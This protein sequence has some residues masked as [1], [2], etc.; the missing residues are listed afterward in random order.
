M[1]KFTI[2]FMTVGLLFYQCDARKEEVSLA[3]SVD[4]LTNELETSQKAIVTLQQIGILM[5]S[6]DANRFLLRVSMLEGT[7]Y[8]DYVSRM[9]EINNYVKKTQTRI[10]ELEYKLSTSKNLSSYTGTIRKLRHDLQK[11]N[12]ELTALQDLVSRYRNKSD[13]LVLTIALQKAALDDNLKQLE[14]KEVEIAGLEKELKRHQSLSKSIEAEAYYSRAQ[15]VEE[16]AN[17]TKFAPRK[18]RK[19]RMEALAL[20]KKAAL[21]GKIEA[22]AKITELQ[23][24]IGAS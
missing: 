3:R 18:K 12:S 1:L 24:K 16:T 17:R 2:L 10:S 9:R 4:S 21:C 8:S 6:I 19:S 13:S 7:P 14:R 11:R 20:Y 5:D 15:A 23:K 22:R